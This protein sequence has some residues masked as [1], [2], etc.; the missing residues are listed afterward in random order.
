MTSRIP[1]E[2]KK[3]GLT[4]GAGLTLET[5]KKML[6]AAE[7][8]GEKQGVPMTIA[9]ADAGGNLIAFNR[10]DNAILCSIQIAMDKAYTAVFKKLPTK[11]LSGS[12]K[13]GEPIP[14]FFHERWITF[15]GGF[16]IISNGVMLGGIG[17]SGGSAY[18]D[19]SVARAALTAGGFNTTDIDA[20]IAEIE[21][22]AK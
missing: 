20:I 2:W 13:S 9:I 18:E 5:A 3:G 11:V 4:Y 12:Y 6:E 1:P 22:M 8:E 15:H 16:P 21:N 19:A 14:L 7:K 10:M 17:V